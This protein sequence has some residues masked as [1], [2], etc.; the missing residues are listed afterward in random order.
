[1]A[2]KL[3][4]V[5]L[6]YVLPLASFALILLTALAI[7]HFFSLTLDPTPLLII[8]MIATAWYGGLGPG[9]LVLLEY[10]LTIQFFTAP[11][12][13]TLKFILLMVNRLILFLSLVLFVSS[14]RSAQNRLQEQSERLRVSLS[15]IGDAVI[16]TDINGTVQFMNSTAE[17]LTGWTIKEAANQP[18]SEVFKIVN[19]FNREVVENP[20]AK[21]LREGKIVGLANHTILINRSGKEI[22][23]DDSGAPIRGV[24]DEIIGVI[25]VFRDISERKH[26]DETR[27]A[28]AAIVESSDDAIIGKSLDGTIRSWNQGAA[29]LYGYSAEEVIGRSVS[30]LM[31]PQRSDDFPAIM[32]KLKRHESIK[33]YETER[34]TKDGKIIHVSLTISPLKD[35]A[36]NLTGASTIA[37][38][39]SGRKQAIKDLQAAQEQLQLVTDT[40]AVAVARC[41]RDLRYLWLSQGYTNWVQRPPEEILGRSIPDVIGAEAFDTIRPYIEQVLNGERVE[42]ENMINLRGIGWRWVNAI[43]TPTYDATNTPDGWVAVIVD[44]TSHK[45][46]EDAVSKNEERFRLAAEAVNGIIYDIDYVTNRLE[47]TRGLLEVLGYQPQEVPATNEWWLAQMHPEDR[48]GIQEAYKQLLASELLEFQYE[49]RLRHRDGRWIYLMDRSVITRDQDGRA[50]RQVGCA[51]DITQIRE[52]EEALKFADRRKDEFLA[53]LA[54][55]LRNPLAPIRNAVEVMRHFS[56]PDPEMER[57]RDIIERQTELLTRLVD[58]LLDV[59]RI[60]QGRIALRKERVDLHTIIDRAVETSRPLIDARKHRLTLAL[61]SAPIEVEGDL[62]RLAQALSNLLNN[63]AKYT[64]S[65]GDIRL[66]ADVNEGEVTVRVKDSGVGIAPEDLPQVFGLFSQVDRSLDRTQGGLGIGLTVVHSLI[67]MHGGRVEA[68]SEG[69][70]KGSEFVVHLPLMKQVGRAAN[71]SPFPIEEEE[72]QLQPSPYYRVLVV[73]DNVDSAESMTMLLKFAGHQVQMAFDGLSALRVARSFLPQVV[74]LDIGLPK[75]NGYEVASELR[76][77]NGLEKAVLIAL[78]GYGQ[79]EDRQRSKLAGFDHHLTKPVDYDR[80]SSL[81]DSLVTEKVTNRG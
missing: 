57:M 11:Q 3:K 59:S 5:G 65:G 8:L 15:S 54:H 49:Y 53:M 14:R 55:E 19:E 71:A 31:P 44:V 38:D 41:S 40:M 36:G 48:P 51:M 67:E 68:F 2:I 74:L 6:R 12:S 28:L 29:K 24:K 33:H 64:P 32:E 35:R 34:I 37:R 1:M 27:A 46:L 81:I 4:S 39:I 66:T 25:L 18:L 75:M 76:K 50:I 9:L 13:L 47:R 10:E 23:I 43:Y 79:A 78:T 58:D 61:P 45:E 22:P 30:I 69:T 17:A 77:E 70:G 63:A 20:V 42:Y 26:A 72:S 60:T 21:V 16:S 62:V 73:D 80:L 7:K 56:S 52:A